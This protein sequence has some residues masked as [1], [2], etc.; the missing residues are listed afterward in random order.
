LV[1]SQ[2][3]TPQLLTE[4]DLNTY[5]SDSAYHD[6]VT[7]WRASKTGNLYMPPSTEGTIY[8]PGL[9]GGAEWGGSAFDPASGL[10]YINSNLMPWLIGMVEVK[11]EIPKNESYLQA[12]Q[13]LYQQ[14]CIACHGTKRE[15]AGN[16]PTLISVNK[17][18][19][20]NTFKELLDGGRRMMPA[21]KMLSSSEVYAIA[22]FILDQ[23]S[24]QKKEFKTAPVPIDSFRN[25]RYNITGYKKFLT[26]DGHPA[27]KPPWGTLNAV[28]LT[29][30]N[31]D[32]SVPLGDEEEFK[33][34]GINSGTENYGGPIVTAGGLIFIAATRDGKFRAFNKKTG[35]VIWETDLPTSAFSSPSMYEVNGKQYVV[36]ACGGGKLNTKS[37]D[38]YVAF[39]LK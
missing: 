20:K 6:L 32:F 37:G 16:Y 12:G 26:K 7:R 5:V 33:K 34:K 21:F 27:I 35:K 23:K 36:I 4:A 14:Y 18:Y 38:Y 28:N 9:D 11:T 25:L 1:A 24:E 10:M 3:F 17:K 2:S 39:A 31:I 15:G 29:T 30:G 13:R 8:F 22:S 19:D